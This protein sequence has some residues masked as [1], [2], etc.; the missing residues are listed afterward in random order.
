MTAAAGLALL[1]GGPAHA[2][3]RDGI[4]AQMT[5]SIDE[6]IPFA[7][8]QFS[9]AVKSV[10]K[11]YPR[12]F[13][14]DGSL[15]TTGAKDWTSGFFPGSLWY[16][17][18]LTGDEKWASEARKS[19]E[20]LAELQHWSGTHDTGFM[21]YC[22][23][24]NGYRLTGDETYKTVIVNTATALEERFNSKAGVMASWKNDEAGNQ[25]TIIDN[26]MNLE[27]TMWASK[28]GGTKSLAELSVIHA[29]TTAVNHFREN[30][31]CYHVLHYDPVSGKV[32]GKKTHQGFADESDW[33]RG[34]AWA[35]YGY[36]MMFRETGKAEYLEISQKTADHM[37]S[38]LPADDVIPR[39]DL[40][41]PA[42]K[43]EK[44]ASAACIMASAFLEIYEHTGK[45][46]HLD[47]AIL[48]LN[49]LSSDDY[50]A[51]GGNYR[52][53][54]I[55]HSIGHYPK[56]TEIDVNINYADYYY[57]ESLVRLKR[58]IENGHVLPK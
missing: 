35:I 12:N 49:T 9:K 52:G 24:G 1:L 11:G 57:L 54:L 32:I 10:N 40:D 39:W 50:L 37:I 25:R 30:G 6:V 41:A 15:T 36:T 17:Y 27:M 3:G 7:E 53:G 26:M 56:G 22:S 23:Y 34:Q 20:G 5:F 19:T 45:E 18:E 31:S 38:R 29:D 16:L 51:K 28:N 42:E 48:F 4:K 8:E 46:K 14:A 21:V 13:L 2:E 43:P 47:L 55:L 58:L 44:D 33:A